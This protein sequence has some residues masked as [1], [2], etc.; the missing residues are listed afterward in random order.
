VST[1][2]LA[3]AM[4]DLVGEVRDGAKLEAA[5]AAIAPEYGLHPS[6][7]VRKFNEAYP[8][9]LPKLIAQ[10]ELK[11]IEDRLI[12]RTICERTGL[13]VKITQFDDATRRDLRRICGL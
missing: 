7:L 13:V 3:D 2:A 6:L 4:T 12:E 5:A 10:K 9:G 11:Q 1:S 8:C